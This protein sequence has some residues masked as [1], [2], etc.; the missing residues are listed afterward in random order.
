MSDKYTEFHKRKLAKHNMGNSIWD[1]L[2]VHN[3]VKT[4]ADLP[5]D[6]DWGDGCMMF[7]IDA[8][9]CFVYR[10]GAWKLFSVGHTDTL[11]SLP[12]SR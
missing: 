1:G 4:I 2:C 11:P 8:D 5:T 3:P 12:R 10:D 6:G 7:V 9:A